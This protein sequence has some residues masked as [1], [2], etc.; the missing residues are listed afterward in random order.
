[1]AELPTRAEYFTIGANEALARAEARPATERVSAE[2]LF[3]EG[4]DANIQNAAA[5][6]MADEVTRQV[7][8]GLKDL[9][10]QSAEGIELDRLVAD[11]YSPTIVRHEATPAVVD[12]ELSRAAGAFPAM[13]LPVGT[14]VRSEGG[15]EFATTVVATM[16]AASLGPVTVRA[17]AVQAGLEGNVARRTL[18]A[19]A[20]TPPDPNLLVTNPDV[21]A[22][23]DAQ[24][25]DSRLRERARSFYS[26]ARR[27]TLGAIEFG[28][29]TVAGVRQATAVELLDDAG[30]P[31]GHVDLYIADAQGQGNA[32]LVAAVD[33]A[34]VEW[35]AAG[36][37]VAVSSATPVFQAITLLLRFEAG[38]D[39]TL[40]FAAVRDAMVARVNTLRP[41][42]T[43]TETLIRGVA[44]SVEGVIVL[45]DAI[46]VPVG[47][48][49]PTGSQVIR[50]TAD[51]VTAA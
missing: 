13:V 6:A 34:L 2:Q 37:I 3:V 51:L 40:A 1:V 8:I 11:R 35:R 50:T 28:A 19:F 46:V 41:R 26:T 17:Q 25:T 39:S 38:I 20:T 22:G 30:D 4:S 15:I 29:L 16:A 42:A 33:I 12:L 44:D 27:G 9:L 21:A 14:V 24:E 7:G 47:D 10:L 45:D 32:A 36:I 5:S 18:T 43:L 48:V 23:G 49:V 31:T